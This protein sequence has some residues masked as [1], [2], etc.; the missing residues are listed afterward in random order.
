MKKL[1]SFYLLIVSLFVVISLNSCDTIAVLSGSGTHGSLASYSYSV[2]K[3]SLENLIN[4]AVG[5]SEAVYTESFDNVEVSHTDETYQGDYQATVSYTFKEGGAL[6]IHNGE[7]CYRLEP[8]TSNSEAF[9]DGFTVGTGEWHEATIDMEKEYA[10][11]IMEFYWEYKEG[12]IWKTQRL[13][14]VESGRK[15]YT[16]RMQPS[17]DQLRVRIVGQQLPQG[18]DVLGY[19]YNINLVKEVGIWDTDT[20]AVDGA[21]TMVISYG[22]LKLQNDESGEGARSLEI[23]IS[24]PGEEY[25]ISCKVEKITAAETATIVIEEKNTGGAWTTIAASSYSQ[26]AS[27][28]NGQETI[29]RIFTPTKDIMRINI[30]STAN[31]ATP[32]E[33]Y[34]D[35]IAISDGQENTTA[36]V[37]NQ[38][39]F[40]Y[41]IHD[42]RL[43]RWLSPDPLE[44]HPYQ[45]GRS[46]YSS[47]WN[48]PIAYRD[49]DGRCPTCPFGIDP[50][51]ALQ[52]MWNAAIETKDGIVELASDPGGAVENIYDA[53]VN[54]EQTYEAIKKQAVESYHKLQ[55]DPNYFSE[56]VGGSAFGT[57][58][59]LLGDKGLSKIKR[60]AAVSNM[61]PEKFIA[62]YSNQIKSHLNAAYPGTAEVTTLGIGT[63]IYR[64]SLKEGTGSKDYFTTDKFA[65]PSDVGKHLSVGN[66]PDAYIFEEFTLTKKIE[67]LQSKTNL[68]KEPGAT[69][70]FSPEI[71]KSS[72]VKELNLQ[73]DLR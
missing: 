12:G 40:K 71:Q 37:S 26:T 20:R 64:Y 58:S 15:T 57:I 59:A 44:A 47:M 53:V 24:Y 11:G 67:V 16:I 23:P 56:L 9:S 70:I 72:I 27:N 33:F 3:D 52:G 45:I 63:K 22:R 4:G 5:I 30:S 55:Y 36:S 31:G 18:E 35:D 29:E 66:N 50:R 46:T 41:R 61:T 19:V 49:P 69:Q 28:T 14:S 7:N 17:S 60:L 2:S 1:I 8:K 43:G 68:I 32:M 51:I 73:L 54:Y 10:A 34:I 6:A 21:S 38:Y 62:K 48:N 65:T 13:I 25:T 42:A 39:A